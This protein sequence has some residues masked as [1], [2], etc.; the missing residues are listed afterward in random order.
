MQISILPTPILVALV[1]MGAP[2]SI[3][4]IHYDPFQVLVHVNNL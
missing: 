2:I 4:G 3:F 1:L